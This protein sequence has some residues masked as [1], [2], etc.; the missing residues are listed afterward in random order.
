MARLCTRKVGK[1]WS[2]AEGDGLTPA[3]SELSHGGR[4][5]YKVWLEEW[6]PRDVL[7]RF[8]PLRGVLEPAGIAVA[9]AL[10]VLEEE[11][12]AVRSQVCE[13]E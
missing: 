5:H 9:R 12:Y 2:A 6:S 13:P 3:R 4:L 10:V 8:V 11:R 1:S 7:V